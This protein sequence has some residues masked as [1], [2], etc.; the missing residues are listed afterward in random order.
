MESEKCSRHDMK[1]DGLLCLDDGCDE[2]LGC[3][4]CY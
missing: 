3:E 1:K 4:Q 2:R